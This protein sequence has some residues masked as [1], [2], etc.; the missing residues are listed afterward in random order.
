MQMIKG[1]GFRTALLGFALLV[2]QLALSM[3]QTVVPPSRL[4][5]LLSKMQ[6]SQQETQTL[7]VSFTQTNEFK[8]LKAPQVLKGDLVLKKPDTALYRYTSPRKLY[9]RVM[10]GDLLMF[11][12]AKKQA[13]LQD[14]SRH[15]AK[16]E[17]YLGL[18]QPVN[19]LRKNF[20]VAWKGEENGVV[21]LY[22]TPL[23]H[24]IKKK[25]ASMTFKVQ[26]T[27]GLIREFE[28]EETEG[29]KIR[30]SFSHWELNPKLGD[31][32]FTVP[33]PTGVKIERKMMNFREPF[34]E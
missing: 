3:A 17:R 18:S 13:Y 14:I 2:G 12:P 24:K 29:D 19:E 32:D 11:D 23:K 9:F 5:V 27:D 21:T 15:Q 4:E 25:V 10:D 33:M 28:V 1:T 30:F 20:D 31:D 6:A 8:M 34:D 26:E 16:I 22:L 7:R